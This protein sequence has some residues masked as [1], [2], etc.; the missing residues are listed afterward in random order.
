MMPAV[1]LI[2]EAP[3]QCTFVQEHSTSPQKLG[4]LQAMLGEHK[5]TSAFTGLDPEA[6]TNLAGVGVVLRRPRAFKAPSPPGP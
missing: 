2:A 1:S 5:L 6:A 4:P 3:V